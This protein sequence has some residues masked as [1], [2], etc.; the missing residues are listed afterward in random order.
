MSLTAEQR[1]ALALLSPEG[2]NGVTRSFLV[3]HG[4]GVSLVNQGLAVRCLLP[5]SGLRV[6]PRGVEES[7]HRGK[8]ASTR[9]ENRMDDP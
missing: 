5:G 4:F 2:H 6:R 9:R 7:A 8:Q 3:A 1:R